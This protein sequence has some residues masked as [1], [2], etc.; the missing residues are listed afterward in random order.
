MKDDDKLAEAIDYF[1][2]GAWLQEHSDTLPGGGDEVRV[3]VCPACGNSSHKLYV[4]VSKKRWLCYVCDWGRGHGDIALLMSHVSGQTMFQVRKEI[5]DCLK[6]LAPRGDL[7]Q[8]LVDMFGK[9]PQAAKAEAVT[10]IEVPGVEAFNGSVGRTALAYARRRGLYDDEIIKY[11]LRA[12]YKLRHFTGPFLVFPNY[13]RGA[14]CVSWQGRRTGKEEPKYVSSDDVAQW[15]WPMDAWAEA[16][17][18]RRGEVVLVEGVFDAAGMWRLGIPALATYGKKI[19]DHQCELLW[20]R[21]VQHITLAWD[22]DSART[23]SQRLARGAKY[24]RGEIEASAMRLKRKF[25]VSVAD[26]SQGAGE[27]KVDPGDALHDHQVED[28]VRDRLKN[29]MSVDSEQFF[30]WRLS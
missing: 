20:E 11:R 4:N 2:L 16:E 13:L 12:A 19:S 10:G 1:D 26:L 17:I 27:G 3:Q 24:L 22:A 9:Q 29:A 18:S 8:K 21:G 30:L 23:T 25:S 28:W 6:P 7:E 5:L 15:L 14:T